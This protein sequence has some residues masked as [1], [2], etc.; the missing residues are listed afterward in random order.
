[1]APSRDDRSGRQPDEE[2]GSQI[3]R[4]LEELK[5]RRVVRASIV[6]AVALFGVL[7]VADIVIPALHLPE[8]LMTGIVVVGA[9]GFPLALALAWTLDVTPH[10]LERT[11]S[12]SADAPAAA[13]SRAATLRNALLLG[14]AV[15]G[16]AA[17]VWWTTRP[18]SASAGSAADIHSLAVLPL[19]NLMGDSTQ[20]PFVDGMHD[21]LIGELQRI[22]DLKV[23][24]QRSVL[25]FRDSDLP[26]PAIADSLHVDALIEGS[27]FRQDDR[28]RVTARLIWG[29]PE[30]DLWRGE[31]EGSLS[32]AMSL[33]SRIAGEVASELQI[34][35]SD[36]T[37]AHMARRDSV[38]PRAMDA[39]LLGRELWR[40]RDL[41]RLPRALE[42]F[43]RAV[44][45]D[46]TFALGWAGVADGYVLGRGYRTLDLPLDEVIR[47]A[48]A[49]MQRAERLDPGLMETHAAR[50][51][52]LLYLEQDFRGAERELSKVIELSPSN[53]QA[54]DWL[55]DALMA[56]GRLDEALPLYQQATELDP[57]FP[58]VHRDFARALEAAGQCERAVS[59]ARK[60]LELDPSHFFAYSMLRDC[61]L[62][63]GDIE[64][65]VRYDFDTYQS[66][67]VPEEEI[68]AARA[69]YDEGGLHGLNMVVARQASESG[70]HVI[71]ATRYAEVGETDEAFAELDRALEE[72]DSLLIQLR[73]DR[74]LAPLHDDPRWDDVLRRL[75]ALGSEH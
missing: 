54:Y 20:R 68:A 58:L 55:G 33:Q 2:S 41:K 44:A 14:I 69:A 28:V 12:P 31:Y 9:L 53:A 26:I 50:G 61:A 1:M 64:Q 57:L 66:A 37:A 22:D 63:A 23:I 65:A 7:Q 38:D 73:T 40:S 8:A 45:I 46:S 36:E 24:S 11:R 19:T 29:D 70:L 6:Y 16:V 47:R 18:R 49:A 27:A 35:L 62:Q 4:L 59:E 3:G 39:Y 72:R 71:A 60:A 32:D 74:G 42:E 21:M 56:L 13:P 43:E 75:E 48:R 34:A 5:R 67:D 10:G 17:S 51:A 15:V 52:L 30:T 25:R